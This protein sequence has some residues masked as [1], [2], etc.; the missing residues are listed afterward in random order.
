MSE[1]ATAPRTTLR[2][3][4]AGLCLLVRDEARADGRKMLHVL[5]PG[6]TE[7][8]EAHEARLYFDSRHLTGV[9][10][11]A[12]LC[13]L[14]LRNALIDL[15]DLIPGSNADLAKLAQL[16]DLARITQKPVERRLI[17]THD[18]GSL[19]KARISLAAGTGGRFNRGG[20]WKLGQNPHQFMPT[21]MEWVIKDL[22]NDTITLD[23]VGLNQT[24]T[25]RSLNLHA[26]ANQIELFI[27][28]SP[29]KQL[30]YELPGHP[31][32]IEGRHPTKCE[33]AHHFSA[34]YPLVNEPENMPLPVYEADDTCQDQGQPDEA[35]GHVH[36]QQPT[37][38]EELR[39]GLDFMCIAATAPAAPR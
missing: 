2:I 21:Y 17:D 16:V 35:G 24:P 13:A 29:A 25:A 5:L 1:Q 26:V 12:G 7:H 23:L 8:A 36:M 14:P 37:G 19:V 18:P 39:M 32:P 15:V 28:H 20:R 6:E 22:P 34:F 27:F 11:A 33:K 4:F 38:V 3:T 31:L 30:P 9:N 10:G